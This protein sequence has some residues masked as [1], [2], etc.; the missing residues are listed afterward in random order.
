MTMQAM[1][2]KQ[3]NPEKCESD[4]SNVGLG[5]VFGSSFGVIVG[6]ITGDIGFW[7]AIGTGLG[8]C[9]GAAFSSSKEFTEEDVV[10]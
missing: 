7:V 4:S 9:F 1:I 5:L 6:S 8:I 2:K 10:D 3:F